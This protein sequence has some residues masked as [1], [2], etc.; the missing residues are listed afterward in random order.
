VA[1]RD[2]AHKGEPRTGEDH[3]KASFRDNKEKKN[4]KKNAHRWHVSSSVMWEYLN[5][6]N[7]FRLDGQGVR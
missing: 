5:N 1:R 2:K 3:E 7:S 6:V 4:K